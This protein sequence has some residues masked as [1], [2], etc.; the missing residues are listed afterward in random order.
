MSLLDAGSVAAGLGFDE[1]LDRWAAGLGTIDPVPGALQLPA[2]PVAAAQLARLGVAEEDA[3]EPLE[4]LSSAA[5]R[6]RAPVAAGA[7][8]PPRPRP[9]R[10]RGAGGGAVAAAAC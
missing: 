4:S 7:M 5:V 1:E 2:R 8:P 6:A 9:A 10:A 3:V